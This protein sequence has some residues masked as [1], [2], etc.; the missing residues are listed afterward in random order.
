MKFVFVISTLLFSSQIILNW[1]VD[2][3]A[4]TFLPP[5]ST[6]TNLVAG[7]V[8]GYYNGGVAWSFIPNTKL[9]VTQIGYKNDYG[10]QDVQGLRIGFWDA[11]KKPVASYVLGDTFAA[12]ETDTNRITYGSIAP[13]VLQAG[14]QYF[15]TADTPKNTQVVESFSSDLS[16]TEIPHFATSGNIAY[17]G[18]FD[19]DAVSGNLF[20]RGAPN[21]V[22]L[23]PTFRYQTAS[24]FEPRLNVASAGNA[25]VLSWP[26]TR[27]AFVLETA[28]SVGSS[29]WQPTGDAPSLVSDQYSVK[30][31]PPDNSP[32]F[33]RLRMIVYRA[34]FLPNAR[35]KFYRKSRSCRKNDEIRA[36]RSRWE[37]L[38]IPLNAPNADSR[39]TPTALSRHPSSKRVGRV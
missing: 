17:G 9:V 6:T 26:K 36:R 30:Y 2:L 7:Q 35:L 25:V 38:S 1:A 24:E 8:V 21:V 27:D 32:R 10:S 20:S 15:I 29:T 19:F 13:L 23:G 33:F 37:N 34:R 31:Q 28:T 5:P 16:D 4:I 39:R 22:I 14:Q 11:A 3:D 12:E 18:L